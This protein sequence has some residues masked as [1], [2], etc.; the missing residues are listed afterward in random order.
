[1]G[2]RVWDNEKY[3]KRIKELSPNLVLIGEYTTY[4]SLINHHCNSCNGDFYASPNNILKGKGCPYC[5]NK[6]VLVGFNDM[7]T[8]NP[9]ICE[10]LENSDDGY[11]YVFGTNKKISFKC[12]SCG[13]IRN[14][15]PLSI[16]YNKYC[17]R[18]RD[19]ISYPEKFMISVLNQ[20]GIK[21]TYQLTKSKQSWCGK[22][23][24][25]FY[26]ENN[27]K[28]VIIE[29]NG[30][31]HYEKSFSVK[32]GKTVKDIRE[33]D[34]KKRELALQYIDNY[35]EIDC[36]RSE[37]N[38]VVKNILLSELSQL[39][40]LSKINFIKCQEFAINSLIVDTCLDYKSGMP[41][42][43]II[44]KYK[45][46]YS[47]LRHY[48]LEGNELGLCSY[49]PINKKKEYGQSVVCMNNKTVY[50]SIIQASRETGV[51]QGA[52]KAS[53]VERRKIKTNKLFDEWLFYNDYSKYINKEV[54]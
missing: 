22:Y 42:N 6:K 30:M 18:C 17:S 34:K 15:K 47:G 12:P 45:I 4:K 39:Y 41:F 7:W 26:F 52:I 38:F 10:L 11:K 29:T 43:D 16:L 44:T 32:D 50:D 33:N 9:E 21:Y 37:Y 36:R 19:S 51:S 23:K 46:S 49:K 40:D 27:E 24:Y 13:E 53:C 20:L 3:S 25:D 1:M 8:T 54:S 28:K 14:T 48:L 2:K 35:I 5:C 31:Q